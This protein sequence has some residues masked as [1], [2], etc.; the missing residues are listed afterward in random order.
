MEATSINS[1]IS[2]ITKY[3]ALVDRRFSMHWKFEWARSGHRVTCSFW[4]KNKHILF[5][6]VFFFFIRSFIRS[7]AYNIEFANKLF[8]IGACIKLTKGLSTK[9]CTLR[10]WCIHVESSVEYACL[11]VGFKGSCRQYGTHTLNKRLMKRNKKTIIFYLVI[12]LEH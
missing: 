11:R 7:T 9:W 1:N 2:V 8:L 4:I 10:M 5:V 3:C 6:C 12:S